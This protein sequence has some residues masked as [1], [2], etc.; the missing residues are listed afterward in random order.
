MS[1]AVHRDLHFVQIGACY[2]FLDVML[3]R[4][5]M[6][7]ETASAR[8][9]RFL[10]G[11][12]CLEDVEWLHSRGLIEAGN[13]LPSFA[14]LLPL[15]RPAS[16]LAEPGVGKPGLSLTLAA[17]IGQ[18]R[19]RRDL[20]DKPLAALLADLRAGKPVAGSGD[21]ATYTA[22]AAA[23]VRARRHVAATD[24]C[25]ARALAMGRMLS[26]KECPFRLII[27]VSAPFSAH[28]WIQ[29]GPFVLTDPLD[30]V[31]AFTPL[32]AI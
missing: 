16:S 9:S 8:L 12:A 32:L 20:L 13:P 24:R 31:L 25:L 28:C 11:N 14:R 4:Y 19:A 1:F 21:P 17:A 27:G 29:A 6:L 26:R 22:V 2:F 15:D 30:R 7:G 18:I 3:D 23:F 10:A 5:F